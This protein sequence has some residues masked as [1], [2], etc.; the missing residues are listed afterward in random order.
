MNAQELVKFL[1]LMYHT[2]CLDGYWKARLA[3]VLQKMGSKV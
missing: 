2:G 3:E 1:K